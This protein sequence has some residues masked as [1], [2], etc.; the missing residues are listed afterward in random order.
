M[1]LREKPDR[2]SGEYNIRRGV[3]KL[4]SH[5]LFMTEVL[6]AKGQGSGLC[7][8]TVKWT[9]EQQNI[10]ETLWTESQSSG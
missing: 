8:P 5:G 3:E 9:M 2:L 7:C 4:R 6:D 1:M 10:W